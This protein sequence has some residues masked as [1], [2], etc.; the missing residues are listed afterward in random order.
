M[1]RDADAGSLRLVR[2]LDGV[3]HWREL[4]RLRRAASAAGSTD[5]RY[6]ACRSRPR[7]HRAAGANSQMSVYSIDRVARVG[8]DGKPLKSHG[9]RV[10]GP[11]VR[12]DFRHRREA[13]AFIYEQMAQRNRQPK[14][15]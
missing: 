3:G 5:R 9:Y 1:V 7:L 11:G 4:Q 12:R 13:V 6:D 14:S 10:I 8:A 2:T 15:V